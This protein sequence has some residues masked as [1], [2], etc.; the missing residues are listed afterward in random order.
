MNPQLVARTGPAKG[1]SRPLGEGVV[2]I[3][4]DPSSTLALGDAAASRNHCAITGVQDV[5]TL[6]DL[7]SL[8]GTFVNGVPV[9]ERALAHGDEIRVGGIVFAFLDHGED[10]PA[11][12]TPALDEKEIR[13]GS[14]VRLRPEDGADHEAERSRTAAE[15]GERLL[16]LAF[17]VLPAE[18]GALVVSG[19]GPGDLSVVSSRSREGGSATPSRTVVSRVLADG[20]AL[21][22]NDLLARD[23]LR[24]AGSLVASCVTAVAAVPLVSRG[25]PCGVLYLDAGG[26]ASFPGDRLALLLGLANLAAPALETLRRLEWLEAERRRLDAV[27]YPDAG[28]LGETPR[29]KE[30]HKL[31]ARAGPT[32]STVLIFGESGTGKELAARAL[33][34]ASPRARRPFVALHGAALSET[35]LESELF[36]HERGAFTGAVAQTRGKLEIADGGTLFLDEVGELPVGTQVK[37]LRVLETRMFERVGGTRPVHVDIRLI[38]A[39]NRDLSVAIKE[40]R[41]REDLFYRLNVLSVTLPPLRERRED[42]PL[43]TS[44]FVARCARRYGKPIAGVTPEARAALSRYDWPRNVRELSNAIER[45]FVL[46]DG[47]LLGLEDLPEPLAERAHSPEAPLARY[48]AAVNE[49]KRHVILA[50]L[51]EAGGR[52]TE[53]ARLLGVHPNY[54]HR[55]IRNLNLRDEKQGSA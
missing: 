17:R 2:T 53:A 50:A 33:H 31:L 52:I 3:G 26:D 35:L 8:N 14:T 32:D 28:L 18:H 43:L 6:R 36:G 24:S 34:E 47:P 48:H 40:D 49:A 39:T 54:L 4:R 44:H 5:F 30:V 12:P 13:F 27:A 19:L 38:A 9:R 21:L 37:L 7:D 20:E 15:L 45:A 25:H 51:S 10:T 23:D 46:A 29:M 55:L 11:P 16:D 41:F 22:S 42:I 1:A